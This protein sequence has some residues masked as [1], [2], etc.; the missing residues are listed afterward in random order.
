MAIHNYNLDQFTLTTHQESPDPPNRT[1]YP[2][3]TTLQQM[4]RGMKCSHQKQAEVL[5]NQFFLAAVI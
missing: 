2:N 1:E 3:T 4:R 5:G